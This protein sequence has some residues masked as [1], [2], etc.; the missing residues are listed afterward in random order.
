MVPC[1]SEHMVDFNLI[2]P[3][4]GNI[5]IGRQSYLNLYTLYT[6]LCFQLLNF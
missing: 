6:F 1:Y 5:R 3:T 4:S 2:V